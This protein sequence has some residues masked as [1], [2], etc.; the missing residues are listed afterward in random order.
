MP[1]K[2][3]Y[4]PFWYITLEKDCEKGLDG[5]YYITSKGC[6][7]CAGYDTLT[8][9]EYIILLNNCIK[10]LKDIKEKVII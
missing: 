10:E 9:N 7:C 5:M 6:S 4:K 8:P 1:N 3:I 2:A